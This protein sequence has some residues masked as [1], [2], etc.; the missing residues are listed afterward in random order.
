MPASKST[1]KKLSPAI[2]EELCRYFATHYAARLSRNLRCMLL[3]YL[4][5]EL[6]VGVPLYLEEMLWQLHDLFELLDRV[7]EETKDWHP[8]EKPG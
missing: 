2:T 4:A 1:T 5:Y 3:D 6:R 8:P 7:E